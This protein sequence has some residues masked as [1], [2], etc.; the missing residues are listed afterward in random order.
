MGRVAKLRLPLTDAQRALAVQYLP[1]ARA[2]AR[3]FKAQ[4]PAGWEEFESAACAALVDA[5]RSF[6]PDRGVKF[7]TFARQRIWGELRDVRHRLIK[8]AQHERGR[9]DVRSPP[10]RPVEEQPGRDRRPVGWELESREE[11]EG[12]LR[13]LPRRHAEAMRL[14][15]LEELTH[16]EAA[17]RMGYT[18]SRVTYLHLE[19]LALLRE[20]SR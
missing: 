15:Y 12:W 8:Q 5:A 14:I 11:A 13:K 20:V 6:E 17:R 3:P 19:S 10:A 2:L 7:P 9:A 1:M 4:L 16:A 18:P